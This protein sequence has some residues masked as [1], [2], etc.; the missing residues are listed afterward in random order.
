MLRSDAYIGQK[1][2]FGRP[3]GEKTLGVIVKIN[4][5]R[6][7]IR[8]LEK[9]GGYQQHSEGGMWSVPPSLCSPANV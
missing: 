7:K 9:R 4:P 5:K 8:T 1:V 3:N 2:F 6:F